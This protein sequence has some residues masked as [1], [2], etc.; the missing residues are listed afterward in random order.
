MSG[1]ERQFRQ[2]SQR[3]IIPPRPRLVTPFFLVDDPCRI[4][5]PCVVAA[6][7]GHESDEFGERHRVVP[8]DDRGQTG[9]NELSFPG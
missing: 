7:V 9:G 4:F 1:I 6:V 5:E 3:R 8:V 2:G